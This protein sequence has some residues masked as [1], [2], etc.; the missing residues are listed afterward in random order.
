VGVENKKREGVRGWRERV[1]VENKKREGVRGWR[2][3][4]GVE[5]KKSGV[6]EREWV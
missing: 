6:G 3:R 2:E 4:V 1:G 5:N